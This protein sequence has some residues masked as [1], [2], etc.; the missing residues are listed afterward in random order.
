MADRYLLESGAPDGFLLEDGS[1]VLI[2]ETPGAFTPSE[3]DWWSGA[4]QCFVGVALAAAA[5]LTSTSLLARQI[6][7]QDDVIGAAPP[8]GQAEMGSTAPAT[9]RARILPTFVKWDQQDD[10]PA[11]APTV[12]FDDTGWWFQE[13]ARPQP[14]PQ[15]TWDDQV[16]PAQAPTVVFDDTGWWFQQPARPQPVPQRTWDDQVLPAL[17]ALAVEDAD[18]SS[19]TTALPGPVLR[20]WS[21]DD[22]RPTPAV[23]TPNDDDPAPRTQATAEVTAILWATNEEIVPASPVFSAD[24]AYWQAPIR[25]LQP[26][27]RQP[28][29]ANDEVVT[30]PPAV[31]VAEEYW[32]APITALSMPSVRVWAE[33]DL[34]PTPAV[35]APNDDDPAPR[36]PATGKVRVTLW[37]TNEEIV[38]QPPPA[39]GQED[40][41]SRPITALPRPNLRVWDDQGDFAP[42]VLRMDEQDWLPPPALVP[43]PFVQAW[44]DGD[45][46]VTPEPPLGVTDEYWQQPFIAQPVAVL[47]PWLYA[48]DPG[49][50][51]TE[52]SIAPPAVMP[53][54]FSAARPRSGQVARPATASASRPRTTN[55]ARPRN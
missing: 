34:R 25:A 50:I 20:I 36:T 46:V 30:V 26:S 14:V 53:G 38:Q 23:F 27:V 40:T 11:Q 51:G 55:T 52:G 6:H 17:L 2:L 41:W 7:Q 43:A 1:G 19:P 32:S 3:D 21:E 37:A 18:W 49:E 13:P 24:D 29:F 28:T 35:F 9:Q 39:I 12:V 22:L 8:Q 44:E 16:L 45:L 42:V 4:Q 10:L 31:T 15:R 48:V 33:E 47:P 5:T 54:A